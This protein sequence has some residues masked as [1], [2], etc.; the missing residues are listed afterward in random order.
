MP[1]TFGSRQIGF[2]ETDIVS[3]SKPVTKKSIQLKKAE[4]IYYILDDLYNRANSGRK[5]PVLLDLPMCLQRKGVIFKNNAKSKYKPKKSRIINIANIFKLLKLEKT[6][7]LTGGVRYSNSVK[8][9]N[10]LIKL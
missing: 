2:Q 1:G 5:G 8:E 9:F 7:I 10:N 6:V 4:D 3:I